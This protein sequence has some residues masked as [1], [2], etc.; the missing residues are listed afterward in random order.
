MIYFTQMARRIIILL[1]FLTQAA[2]ASQETFKI[3]YLGFIPFGKALLTSQ[4][5]Q[6]DLTLVPSKPVWWISKLE[7][8]F[9]IQKQ[10]QTVIYQEDIE[11]QLG[12]SDH[13]TLVYDYKN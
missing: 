10:N 3:K 9:S 2:I 1:L 5:A 8:K 6:T 13:K 12:S 4:D 7:A 11:N